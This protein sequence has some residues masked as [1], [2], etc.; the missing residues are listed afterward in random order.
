M[1]KRKKTPS[2]LKVKIQKSRPFLEFLVDGKGSKKLEV[3]ALKSENH[4]MIHVYLKLLVVKYFFPAER[5]CQRED[6]TLGWKRIM[7]KDMKILA[8]CAFGK[9]RIKLSPW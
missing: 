9:M 3:L 5:Q 4:T 2:K 1:S 6:I 8:P 7:C